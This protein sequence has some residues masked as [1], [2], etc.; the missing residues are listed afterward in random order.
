MIQF[1][2]GWQFLKSSSPLPLPARSNDCRCHRLVYQQSHINTRQSLMQK[3]NG[4]F[5]LGFL[6]ADDCAINSCIFAYND[7][8]INFFI[9]LEW[10]LFNRFVDY[11]HCVLSPHKTYIR[12]HTTTTKKTHTHANIGHCWTTI[13]IVDN[14]SGGVQSMIFRYFVV[15]FLVPY[16]AWTKLNDRRDAKKKREG[17]KRPDDTSI[18]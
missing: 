14:R 7:Y 4:F 5:S 6:C 10:F 15:F 1:Y 18:P 8:L 17:K 13:N 16:S 3:L 11:F 9:G 2:F 12:G